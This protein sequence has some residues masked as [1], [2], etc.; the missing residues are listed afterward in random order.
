TKIK[1]NTQLQF[2]FAGAESDD[3]KESDVLDSTPEDFDDEYND[4]ENQKKFNKDNGGNL[5][6][7]ELGFNYRTWKYPNSEWDYTS[8]LYT[9]HKIS[10][11]KNWSLIYTANF[12]L[13]EKEMVLNKF[14]IYRP[15]HCWEF[16]FNFWPQGISSGFSLEIKVKNPDLQDI[17]VISSDYKRG[18]SGY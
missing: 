13:K 3:I 11:S 12:N 5:W 4:G 15:L 18:F 14:S 6:E 16:S 2:K 8:S 17:K 1:L 9:T 7:T 10:L